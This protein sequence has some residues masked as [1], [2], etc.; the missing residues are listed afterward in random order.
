VS[1][2]V[3]S[4][5]VGSFFLVY[6]NISL[7]LKVIGYQM[8]LSNEKSQ[9]DKHFELKSKLRPINNHFSMV[10]IPILSHINPHLKAEERSRTFK[11]ISCCEQKALPLHN[12][13]VLSDGISRHSHLNSVRKQVCIF[14]NVPGEVNA[15]VR[16][17]NG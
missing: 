10:I 6:H 9:N 11:P 1:P 5:T 16:E 12:R 14:L 7:Y 2:I 8:R 17:R 15:A 13:K 4:G 3:D